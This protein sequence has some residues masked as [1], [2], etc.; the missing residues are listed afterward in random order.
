MAVASNP[1]S[2]EEQICH[3]MLLINMTVQ[4]VQQIRYNQSKNEIAKAGTLPI[5][6]LPQHTCTTDHMQLKAWPNLMPTH[7]RLH[8]IYIAISCYCL[9][10]HKQLPGCN[11]LL[12]IL[13]TAYSFKS[14]HCGIPAFTQGSVGRPAIM[15]LAMQSVYYGLKPRIAGLCK[16]INLASSPDLR[17]LR[18]WGRSYRHALIKSFLVSFHYQKV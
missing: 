12:L 8:C 5:V 13:K 3:N 17:I 1:E 15:L 7:A 6:C 9:C 11:S 10:V 16:K 4:Y 2:S 18:E 14:L